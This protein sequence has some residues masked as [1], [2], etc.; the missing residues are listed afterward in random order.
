MDKLIDRFVRWHRWLAVLVMLSAAIPL[1]FVVRLQ[2]DNSIEVWLD[3]SS[4]EYKTYRSFLEHY[5]SEEFIVVAGDF[6]NPFSDEAIDLQQKLAEKLSG[7]DG[8]ARVLDLP[9]VC[10]AMWPD[11]Q[12]WQSHLRDTEF[13]NNLLLGENGRTIGIIV[14]LE[15]FE[16][17]GARRETVEAIESAV[18]SFA[19]KGFEPHLAGTPLMNVEL[20]RGSKKAAAT[21]LP[22][23]LAISVLVLGFML[24]SVRGVIAPM[25]AVGVTTVWAAGIMAMTGRTMNMVT[26]MLPSLLFILSLSGGIHIAS[27]FFTALR[28]LGDRDQAVKVVLRELVRPIFLRAGHERKLSYTARSIIRGLLHLG[29]CCRATGLVMRWRVCLSC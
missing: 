20:D 27:R 1:Y 24:R 17:V 26:V 11:K 29:V 23:A 21:L 4:A 9:A 19:G 15:R 18:R 3:S 5:E 12:L 13:L 16:E 14:W 22:V 2:M 10:S 25:C 28:Q 6:T 7:I 8:V